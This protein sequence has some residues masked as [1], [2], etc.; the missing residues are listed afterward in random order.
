MSEV[1]GLP[2]PEKSLLLQWLAKNQTSSLIIHWD[3][4]KKKHLP[5]TICQAFSSLNYF[6]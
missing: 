2:S 3:T 4:A 5:E 6:F 1:D